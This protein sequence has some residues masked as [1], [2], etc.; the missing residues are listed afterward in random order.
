MYKAITLAALF[1]T[2][3]AQNYNQHENHG[4]TQRYGE[5]G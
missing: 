5:D 1:A 2:S 3:S 4:Q